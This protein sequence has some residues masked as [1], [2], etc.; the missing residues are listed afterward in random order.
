[1]SVLLTEIPPHL[2]C[3]LINQSTDTS[4]TDGDLVALAIDEEAKKGIDVKSLLGRFLKRLNAVSAVVAVVGVSAMT[5][6]QTQAGFS[7]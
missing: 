2:K 6:P 1:M 7:I 4:V 5:I 3:R